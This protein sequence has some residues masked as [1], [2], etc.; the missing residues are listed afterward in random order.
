MT[1]LLTPMINLTDWLGDNPW[2]LW[3]S[4]AV[5]LG[6]A[7]I[8]SLDLVLIMIAAGAVGGGLVAL[9]G[10]P[11]LVQ[12]VVAVVISGGLIWPLLLLPILLIAMS[13]TSSLSSSPLDGRARRTITAA[14]AKPANMPTT[15]RPAVLSARIARAYSERSPGRHGRRR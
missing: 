4:L 14:A 8:V 1:P 7:E 13:A 11:R 3:F 12:I 9:I 15:A 6:I 10:G 5:L 2:A